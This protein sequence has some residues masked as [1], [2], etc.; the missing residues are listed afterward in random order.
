MNSPVARIHLRGPPSA[1]TALSRFRQVRDYIKETV[2][3]AFRRLRDAGRTLTAGRIGQVVRDAL[4][5]AFE[6]FED[7]A[8]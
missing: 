5:D 7:Y 4:K 1:V 3:A 8:E 6:V 2:A